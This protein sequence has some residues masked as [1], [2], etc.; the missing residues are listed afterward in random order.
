MVKP[1]I[2]KNL[3]IDEK[4]PEL[5]RK[6]ELF[7]QTS[8]VSKTGGWEVDLLNN[9]VSWT[10]VT[11]MIHE[12]EDDFNLDIE[13]GINFYK[14]G[15]SRKKIKEL[16]SL[17]LQ[18]EMGYDAELQLITAKGNERW[19]RTRGT[20]VFENGK[21]V[22]LYGTIQDIHAE[23]LK[24]L[25][26]AEDENIFRLTLENAPIGMALVALSGKWMKVNKTLCAMVGYSEEEL[27]KI[28]FQKITHWDDLEEDLKLANDL[29]AGK[30]Q[31]YQLEKRYI[32]KKGY[33]I[34]ILLSVS[35]VKDENQNPLY[36]ISHIMDISD[37]K[38]TEQIVKQE[39]QLLI[40]L[41]NYIPVNIFIKDKNFKKILVN[42]KELEYLG[43]EN[44]EDILGKDDFDLYPTESAVTSLAEDKQIFST[45]IPIIDKETFNIKK[46]GNTNWFLTSK[47]PLKNEQG[48]ISGLLGISYDINERKKLQEKQK[49]LLDVTTEQNT[50]LVNFAHIVSHNLKSVSGN[51][52]M[53]INEYLIEKNEDEK[54][55]IIEL[56]KKSSD[57][58]A[59]TIIN[60]NEIVDI[61]NKV[62]QNFSNI[63]LHEAIEKVKHNVH[64]ILKKSEI[65]FI[66]EV[67]ED[68]TIH[69]VPAYLE[70][71]LLNLST[72]SLKYK[73]T[74]KNSYIKFSAVKQEQAVLFFVE[75]NGKGIDMK[76]HG[77]KLFGMYKTFHGNKDAKGV[78]LFI[79]KNQIEA[80]GGTIDVES[81]VG[82]GTKFKIQF[83]D[84]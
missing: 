46:D 50:R 55:T 39:R 72:N 64:S 12:V 59:D 58:L 84:K 78:G 15:E 26:I 35:L 80:M 81:E 4:L 1:A 53:L 42:K 3:C 77:T 48:E 2:S 23:K 73:C 44:E 61:H 63:P 7:E 65:D 69:A 76:R 20:S 79:T 51:F 67:P 11:K 71:I 30:I 31:S 19:I 54:A 17:A 9:T 52:A 21:C 33:I 37:R 27:L 32:H 36:F 83:N 29:V 49:N 74:D 47:I 22:R 13:A 56:L 68:I 28:D 41:I 82:I 75:D 43:F 18:E 60:L 70:S 16:V 14:P 8:I 66:N 25:K 45:G 38:R 34:Y 24:D 10:A 57:N 40:T 62:N 6:L 5:Q